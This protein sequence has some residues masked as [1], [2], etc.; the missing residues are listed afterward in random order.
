[1][2]MNVANTILLGITS[3]LLVSIPAASQTTPVLLKRDNGTAR[4]HDVSAA[5]W[6]ET[7]T[8]TTTG[9]CRLL[10]LHIYYDGTKAGKDTV[11]IVGDP[12][13][14][15]VPPTSNV[16]SYNALAAPVVMSYDGTPGWDTID[17]RAANIHYDGYDR[18]VIQHRV[19]TGGPWFAIDNNGTSSTSV[20]YDPFTYP[21]N[22]PIPGL[23]TLAKGDL[24]VRAL[25]EYD[26]PT[27]T[28]SQPPPA[29]TFGDAAK[30]VGLVD[31]AGK[32]LKSA[33]V[34][35]ADWNG[36]GWDDIA[37]GSNFFQNKGDGTF[38]SVNS[39]IGIASAGASVWGDFDNDGHL[40][41][42][43]INGGAGDRIYRNDGDG[44]FTDITATSGF[45][46][47]YPTVTPIWFDYN[48]DGK[49]DIFI[50]NG[51]TENNGVEE[52]FPDQLWRGNGNGT[53]TN[54]TDDSY[55]SVSEN[56]GSPDGFSF[57]DCWGAAPCDY[58]NDGWTDI[59]VAT[60]RLAPDLLLR[61]LH[62]GVFSDEA[63]TVG[64]QGAPTDVPYYF[65]HGIGVDWGDYNND[66]NV[67]LM[68]GNLGHPDLR[69]LNS[70]PS[71][72]Y[73]N[74]GAPAYTF[75][76]VHH[77]VGIKFFEMNAGVVWLDLDLDGYLDLWHCQYAYE[78]SGANAPK[79]LSRVYFNQGPASNYRML[80]RTWHTG[81][82]IHGAWT[83]ARGDFDRDGDIDLIAAS[84]TEAVKLFLNNLDRNGEWLSF[85]LVGSPVNNVPMDGYGTRIMVYA[86][87]KMMLRELQGG[88]GG[89]TGTQ[90]SNVLHFG[91]G[92]TSSAD[93][94]VVRYP[95][96]TSRTYTNVA[97]NASYTIPYQGDL[98][99]TSGVALEEKSERSLRL[100][101]AGF[102][103]NDFVFHLHAPA[104]RGDIQAEVVNSLGSVIASGSFAG[105][106]SGMRSLRADAAVASGIYF[107]RVI[108][109]GESV[110]E[111]VS[112]VR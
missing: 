38:R 31:A 57:L 2:R 12:A 79:R 3:L 93:S 80:D 90:N 18:I 103:G 87:G 60:Y 61:N 26:F 76:E 20:I 52:Y 32:P 33:R 56:L 105:G 4:G 88:G 81:P 54:V 14:G 112:V 49:L 11:W 83:A 19:N 94:V 92:R 10:E 25:V 73:K 21:A 95:N 51:R 40:D 29:A 58:D 42:Y 45:E 48:H 72:L 70:N 82:V 22:F 23:Y 98:L 74:L 89:T 27:S 34:S 111:K 9:P 109:G 108:A 62:D 101:G 97:G 86:G 39:E 66:G 107:V 5:M 43:A 8:L 47:P 59:F 99:M 1:M 46:N 84:P 44:S 17:L 68:V 53:F 37:I 75:E 78:P 69:G 15:A 16:W 85:R 71:L 24:M 13:E 64:V 55:I 50:A 65:G 106:T 35:V 30:A 91:I 104:L 7:M 36:D 77:D 102:N 67:D 63:V 96:G 110:V 28:G 6:E 100:S 41:C